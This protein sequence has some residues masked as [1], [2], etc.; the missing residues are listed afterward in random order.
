[1]ATIL[2]DAPQ[3]AYALVPDQDEALPRDILQYVAVPVAFWPGEEQRERARGF[4]QTS[5]HLET[6]DDHVDRIDGVLMERE[7]RCA[8]QQGHT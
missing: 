6:I 1:M 2:S 7:F 4:I 3:R 8:L 5:L